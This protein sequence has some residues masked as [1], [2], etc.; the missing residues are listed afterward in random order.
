MWNV[1]VRRVFIWLRATALAGQ[2]VALVAAAWLFGPTLAW[3]C[4]LGVTVAYGLWHAG[5]LLRTRRDPLPAPRLLWLELLVDLV[6][7]AALL[8]LAGGWTNPFTSLLLVPLAFAAAVLP[9]RHA[10]SLAA[11]ALGLYALLVRVHLPLP[12]VQG[13]F[14]GDFSVHVAG[15]WASFVFAAVVLVGTVTLVRGALERERGRLARAREARLRDEQLV[16]IGALAAS[17]AHEL[18]TPLGSAR[19]IAE[20]LEESL[21]GELSAQADLLGRQLDAAASRLRLLVRGAVFEPGVQPL[22]LPAFVDAL[23]DRL[24]LLRPDTTLRR[25]GPPLPALPLHDCRLLES[26]LLGLLL[27]AADASA[28]AGEHA[29]D[30]TVGVDGVDTGGGARTPSGGSLVV[31]IRDFGSGMP[32]GSGAG[33]WPVPSAA[34]MGVGLVISSATFE[35]HGGS[36]HHLAPGDGRAGTRVHV[37]LPLAGMMEPAGD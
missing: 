7:L 8:A 36:V 20:E 1:D 21:H 11:V 37:R 28:A 23:L 18:A 15:M 2:C 3:P 35:R 27:N 12:S 22:L 30:V 19:L 31:D 29:V 17:A 4:M 10:A 13:R 24:A 25:A 16:A 33:R 14:G 9:A 26:A 32:A 34:G 5:F 6:T